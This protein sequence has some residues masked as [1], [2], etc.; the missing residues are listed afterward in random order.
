MSRLSTSDFKVKSTLVQPNILSKKYNTLN[1]MINGTI[2]CHLRRVYS[3][4]IAGVVKAVKVHPRSRFRVVLLAHLF[5][6]V[7]QNQR[8]P[9]LMVHCMVIILLHPIQMLISTQ[10]DPLVE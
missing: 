2:I 10:L 1:I 7:N 6:K 5:L 8:L 9:Q 3:K 4:G